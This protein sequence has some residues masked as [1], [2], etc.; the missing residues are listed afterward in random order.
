MRPS[1]LASKVCF[2]KSQT[3]M[4]I[5]CL[6][7]ARVRLIASVW[8][9]LTTILVLPSKEEEED[10]QEEEAAVILWQ[11]N[12]PGSNV[13]SLFS[14][15]QIFISF[16]DY[17][18]GTIIRPGYQGFRQS[19]QTVMNVPGIP[20][21]LWHLRLPSTTFNQC[22]MLQWFSSSHNLKVK[23]QQNNLPP[24]TFK[25]DTLSQLPA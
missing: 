2:S 4:Q 6:F 20:Y 18:T 24:D 21:V 8:L 5:Q 10:K 12:D 7:V 9:F 16:T 17:F 15:Y 3:Y 22:N 19:L 23:K 1:P 13:I 14:C 11:S 25:C